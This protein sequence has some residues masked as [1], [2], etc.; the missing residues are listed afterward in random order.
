MNTIGPIFRIR[1]LVRNLHMTGAILVVSSIEVARTLQRIPL[2]VVLGVNLLHLQTPRRPCWFPH[3]IF[4][5]P[6]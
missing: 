5:A 4:V 3:H 1:V 6:L 2:V